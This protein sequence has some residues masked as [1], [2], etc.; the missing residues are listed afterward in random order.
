VSVVSTAYLSEVFR[1][2]PDDQL[3]FTND[4]EI[5]SSSTSNIKYLWGDGAYYINYFGSFSLPNQSLST[6]GDL[7]EFGGSTSSISRYTITAGPSHPE[8]VAEGML[9]L[10]ETLSA[11]IS[12]SDVS[13]PANYQFVTDYYSGDDTFIASKAEGI[14]ADDIIF[15]F[16]GNDTF[17]TYGTGERYDKVYAGDGIDTAVYEA[18]RSNFDIFRAPNNIYN[19]LTDA[20]DLE[21]FS[22]VD[23]VG[24]ESGDQLV[25]VE[26]LRFTN[27][28]VALDFGREQNSYKAAAMITTLFGAD[29]IPT[30]FGPA[31][32][33]IDDG[34]SEIAIA[35]LVI[36]LGL[37]ESSSNQSF[38]AEIYENVVGQSP[39]PLTLALYTSQL[40]KGELTQA[41][42][43]AIGASVPLIE[44]QITDLSS[45]R[46]SG[47]EY[48]G[49]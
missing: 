45:W 23:R 35:Q 27:T 25:D 28:N 29:L 18:P 44:A 48:L 11:P 49:F 2:G 21:G 9:L 41:G 15:G 16:G 40:D 1:N 47:L 3:Y 17:Y 38:V 13:Q 12:L 39:D 7:L 8:G 42:L 43:V 32:G 19:V 4:T 6:Y 30:Y 31:V 34:M 10:K 36:D 46:E 33:L 26:R 24:N 5:I 20:R 14:A 37:I 22:V